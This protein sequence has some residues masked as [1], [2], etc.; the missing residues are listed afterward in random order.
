LEDFGTAVLVNLDGF[1]GNGFLGL[2]RRM[3]LSRIPAVSSGR[4]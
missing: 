4:M 3:E 1:H 2:F